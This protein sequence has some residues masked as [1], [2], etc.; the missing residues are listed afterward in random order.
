MT[1]KLV[2]E[3]IR[4]KP[5]RSLLSILLIGVPVTLILSLVGLSHGMLEDSQRRARG[6]GADLIVRSSNAAT[7]ISFGPAAVDQRLIRHIETF[8]HV[9]MASGVINHPIDLPLVL[10]GIDLAAFTRLNGGFQFAE[11]G[12]FRAPDDILV[13]KSYATQKKLKVGSTLK[14]LNH[15]WH[16]RGIILGG[17]LARLAVPL[18]TLQF[19]D[20]S[21][22]KVSQIYVKVDNPANTGKVLEEL[23][24]GLRGYR[25]DTMAD[26]IAAFNVNNIQ[27]LKEFI[28][29]IMA[30][31]VIIGFAV[32]CLSMYMSVLQRTREIGI[33]KSLGASK[34]FILRIV[35]A[36]ALLLGVG[37]TMLGIVMSYGAYWLIAQLVPASIPMIIVPSWWPIAGAVTLVGAALG[38]VYPGWTA[39]SHDPIE[40]LAYE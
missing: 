32:V 4:H 22:G 34:W 9:A 3:N 39:A 17:K 12:P 8:P 36:E 15:D 7:A 2:F 38:S 18:E 6:V 20:S 27:G 31:G 10:T 13:D 35:L 14:L 30:I 21:T 26:Y 1:F 5:M 11:G 33:L 29:V 23:T 19:L 28:G 25:I 40:A 16:V 24:T 37:G